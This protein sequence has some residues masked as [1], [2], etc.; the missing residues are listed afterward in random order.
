VEAIPTKIVD[1]AT[2]MK[3]LK[4]IIFPRFGIPRFLITDDSSN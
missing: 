1:H 2:T 4:D 3:I